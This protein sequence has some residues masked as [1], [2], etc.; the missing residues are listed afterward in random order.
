MAHLHPG[1]GA[2]QEVAE[3]EQHLPGQANAKPSAPLLNAR[4]GSR[5]GKLIARP[6]HKGEQR[7]GQQR[8][9]HAAFEDGAGLGP[10]VHVQPIGQRLRG[11]EFGLERRLTHGA[12]RPGDAQ[13]DLRDPTGHQEEERAAIRTAQGRSASAVP[14]GQH[15]R[16]H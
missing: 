7:G 14:V 8:V 9:R 2:H 1:R 4:F 5:L 11:F 15:Q 12:D 16:A 6:Q 3:T 10:D 13:D